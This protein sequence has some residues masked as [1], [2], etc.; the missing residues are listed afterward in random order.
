ML[1]LRDSVTQDESKCCGTAG[2]AHCRLRYAYKKH[3]ATYSTYHP[4]SSL[5]FD[6]AKQRT[7]TNMS[8]SKAEYQKEEFIADM[9]PVPEGEFCVFG[10]V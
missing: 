1:S 3:K 4:K 8:F 2:G 7:T 5:N 10:T 9:P 6:R